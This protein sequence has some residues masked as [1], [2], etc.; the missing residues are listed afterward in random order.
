MEGDNVDRFSYR[1]GG[2]SYKVVV[3][4]IDMEKKGW[5]TCFEQWE[6]E[7]DRDRE[8]ELYQEDSPFTPTLSLLFIFKFEKS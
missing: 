6:R 4:Q 5:V 3:L 7:R 8:R 2:K 1:D